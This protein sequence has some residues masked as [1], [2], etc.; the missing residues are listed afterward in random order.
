MKKTHIF[1]TYIIYLNNPHNVLTL[2]NVR[3]TSATSTQSIKICV[4]E[5]RSMEL[6]RTYS[7]RSSLFHY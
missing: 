4:S 2:Q 7:G 6:I 5:Y 1:R 3:R